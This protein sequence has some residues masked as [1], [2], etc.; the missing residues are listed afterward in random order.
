MSQEQERPQSAGVAAVMAVLAP[1][2]A[3]TSAVILLSF[4]Y[5][6]QLLGVGLST[7]RTLLA[8][9]WFFGAVT[10]LTVLVVAASLVI[11]AMHATSSERVSG[12]AADRTL[13]IASFL[14]GTRRAHLREEWAG[15]LAGDPE[16]GLVLRPSRRLGYALG[17]LWAAIRLRLRDLTAPLWLPVDW[18]LSEEARTNRFIA[19]AVG[20]QAVYIVGDGGLPA[21]FTEVWEPCTLFG[22]G[23]YILARWLRRVR[24]IE[25][26]SARSDSSEAD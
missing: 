3:G 8:T 21:L 23:L 16:T 25:L 20:G 1:A 24:G 18:L 10:A 4:G 2:L 19:L 14:V 12:G 15:L 6:M 26:A 7:S 11:T 22:A 13:R 9:G 5:T 17:F